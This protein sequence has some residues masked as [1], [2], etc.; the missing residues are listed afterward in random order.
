[1]PRC[2]RAVCAALCSAVLFAACH[3]GLPST[4]SSS[5]RQADFLPSPGD[6][7]LV[8]PVLPTELGT[9]RVMTWNVRFASRR[10]GYEDWSTRAPD[11]ER[12]LAVSNVD[13]L[14]VQEMVALKDGHRQLD[15]MRA[16]LPG[17]EYI[18][19]SRS[20]T[21]PDDE[22]SGVFYNPE[23][24]EVLNSGFFWLSPAPMTP[25]SFGYGNQGNPRM[26][27]WVEFKNRVDG[28]L[29]TLVNT[30]FDHRSSEARY[31]SADQ[32]QGYLTADPAYA[33][34]GVD[35]DPG[36]PMVF[37]GDFNDELRQDENWV[38]EGYRGQTIDPL[39]TVR[40]PLLFGLVPPEIS[41]ADP[42]V[43]R[44]A[45]NLSPYN[46]LVT[47]GSFVDALAMAERRFE[48]PVGTYS[49]FGSADIRPGII[50]WI[51]VTPDVRVLQAYVETYAPNGN[52]PSDHLPVV[53]DVQILR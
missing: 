42:G 40:A 46:R 41:Q 28:S 11:L 26:A 19:R 20:T 45:G 1:M 52:F 43:F 4:P 47:N 30:H 25:G 17:Y 21:N 29:F 33:N 32:V 12:L 2:Y 34:D 14:G 37:I 49:A 5:A 50:D 23:S 6:D 16:M 24:L 8:A 7:E 13:I 18:G 27:T 38:P 44:M 36:L 39:K 22:Q 31:R 48:E 9:L 10:D 15:D 35:I 3:G 51:L 53:A